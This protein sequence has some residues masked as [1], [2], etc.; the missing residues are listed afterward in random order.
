MRRVTLGK[1]LSIYYVVFIIK[2]YKWDALSTFSIRI[3][4]WQSVPLIVFSFHLVTKGGT[5]DRE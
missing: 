4:G 2:P 3:S 5:K 1:I